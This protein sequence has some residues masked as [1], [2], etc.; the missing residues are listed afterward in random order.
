MDYLVFLTGLFL[1][2]AGVGCLFLHREERQIS[3]WPLL[4]VSLSA[5]CISIWWG[6]L[7]F[8]LGVDGLA[9]PVRVLLGAVFATS[10]FGFCLSPLV[11][12]KKRSSFSFK[13]AAMVALFAVT[14]TAGFSSFN[15]AVYAI[16]IIGV[17]FLGGLKI[18]QFGKALHKQEK[19]THPFITALLF[20]IIAAVSL[21]PD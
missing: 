1:L 4:A 10:L 6:I 12:V 2:T 14:F 21:L 13:W 18:S 7:V 17:S 8:T 15:S 16:S 3:R 5:L 11:N 20:A 19:A 9:S